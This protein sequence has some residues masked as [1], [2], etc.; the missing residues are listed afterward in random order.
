MGRPAGHCVR[1][2]LAP[3]LGKQVVGSESARYYSY[4]CSTAV[5]SPLARL[6][7]A[8]DELAAEDT[9]CLGDAER[10]ERV[11]LLNKATNRATA[12]LAGAI[13]NAETHQSPE[14][15]G[16][17][18]MRSWLR[19]H[20][21]L[22]GAAVTGLVREGRAM[23]CLPAVEAAFLAGELTADQVDTIA[24]IATPENLDK[25]AAQG[26]DLDVIE[27]ALVAIAVTQPYRTLQ[28]EVGGYLAR[29][30]PDGREPDPTEQRSLTLVQHPDGAVTGGL[31]L[32]QHGGETVMTAVEAYA[33]ASRT[34]GDPR[35]RAQRLADALVQLCANALAT[36]QAPRLRSVPAQLLVIIDEH[37]L[38][39][40]DPNPAAGATGT[41]ARISATRARRTACDSQVSRLVF[42]PDSVPID[43]GRAQRVVTP[44]QRRALDARDGS[45]VFAGCEAPNWWC[46]AH[47]V[48]EWINDGPTDLENL[49][50]LCERHHT[51]AH[52]GFRVE[53]DT[54]GRWHTY[55]PDG[56]EIVLQP[57]LAA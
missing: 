9:S 27:R 32:D 31:S 26:I 14:H 29:L 43:L 40:P 15:D 25:A 8:L 4:M 22:S 47:H 50:L 3:D 42:G 19:T 1:L 24:V 36:G 5:D 38:V 57:P 44:A 51:K 41:G 21:R 28:V 48:L 30:D 54:D 10:L 20:T 6:A 34:A 33:A 7:A 39:D 35:S 16:L 12:Q 13:R 46:E 49:G 11:R 52:H 45:C 53:R 17:K 56:T 55:R 2:N 23:A 37:A 18:S